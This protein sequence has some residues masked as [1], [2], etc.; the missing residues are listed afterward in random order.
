MSMYEI[1]FR[2]RFIICSVIINKVICWSERVISSLKMG[3]N[4]EF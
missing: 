4:Y 1:M 2:N 3:E